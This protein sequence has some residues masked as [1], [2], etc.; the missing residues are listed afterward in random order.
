MTATCAILSKRAITI[1][2]D[3]FLTSFAKTKRTVVEAQRAKFLKFERLHGAVAYWGL[4]RYSTWDLHH[5]LQEEINNLSNGD[6]LDDW[7]RTIADKL[8]QKYSHWPPSVRKMG[9]GIHLVGYELV[10]N[11]RVP[12][13][14]L[15]G[16]FTGINDDGSYLVGNTFSYSRRCLF[17]LRRAPGDDPSTHGLLES[18]RIMKNYFQTGQWMMFNNGDTGLFMKLA[19]GL[20]SAINLAKQRG[21]LDT[22][23]VIKT[24]KNIAKTTIKMISDIQRNFFREN[25]RIVGGRTH[26]LT[27]KANGEYLVNQ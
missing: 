13:M 21:N 10:D 22:S 18:R 26:T 17:D 3:S 23:D 14:W 4:A 24:Q 12:E 25:C 6:S 8:N 19:A 27:I 1:S 7:A 5:W 15:I 2:C 9:L 20:G 16:N 11:C